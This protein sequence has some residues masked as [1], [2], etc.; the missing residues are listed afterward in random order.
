[1]R[2]HPPAHAPTTNNSKAIDPPKDTATK[3]TP[4]TPSSNPTPSPTPPPPSTTNTT[5]LQLTEEAGDLFAAPPSTLLI[6][7]CNTLGAWS[8][9][10]ALAFKSHYPLA[11]K[12]YASHCQTHTPEQLRGTALLIPPSGGKEKHWIGCLIT[13]R[14]YGRGRDG[15]AQILEA[16]GEGMRDFLA[17][18]EDAVGVGE[19]WMCRVNSGKFRVPWGETRRVLEGVEV[20]EG[21]KVREVKVVLGD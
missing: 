16:T 5:T 19:V 11:Y 10:I 7:A 15:R 21:C 9:G 20:A 6:H 1:M 14:R 2:P 4:P 17:Q 12:T 13:S 3:P 8:A 18:V